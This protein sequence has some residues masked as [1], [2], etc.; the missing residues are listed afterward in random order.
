MKKPSVFVA[1]LWVA[2]CHDPYS[3]DD[4]LFL[5]E[6]VPRDIEIIVPTEEGT[7]GVA[8]PGGPP[9]TETAVFYTEA[10]RSADAVNRDIL[11]LLTWIDAIVAQPPSQRLDDQRVWGPFPGERNI[12]YTFVADRVRTS[13]V[14]R[15]TSTS[16]PAVTNEFFQY[17]MWGSSPSQLQPIVLFSG[18]QVADAN[19]GGALGVMVIDLD[20]GRAV[21]PNS[22]GEG[23]VLVGYDNRFQ[24]STVELALGDFD[25]E[26]AVAAWRNTQD[27]SGAG[28]FIFFIRENFD[29]ASP[30]LELWIIAARWLADGRGRA[31]VLVSEGDVVLPL[32]ASECWNTDFARTYLLSNIPDPA[33]FS[34]GQLEDCAPSLRTAQFPE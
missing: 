13:T 1:M 2:A 16:T 8:N 18:R 23:G 30:D 4:L 5:Y 34:E 25:G 22:T 14:F 26:G 28:T 27:A 10:R 3:N 17:S 6:S 21:D 7:T 24:Q 32:F 12:R 15:A 9:A 11:S 29:E 19:S 20:A 31:D 33:Y